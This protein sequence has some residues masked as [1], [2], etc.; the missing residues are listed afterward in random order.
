MSPAKA[1]DRSL[2]S[3]AG[4]ARCAF[5]AAFAVC[6]KQLAPAARGSIRRNPADP[7][8]FSVQLRKLSGRRRGVLDWESV[9]CGTTCSFGCLPSGDS[10][11]TPAPQGRGTAAR[12]LRWASGQLGM[13]CQPITVEVSPLSPPSASLRDAFPQA[14]PLPWLSRPSPTAPSIIH[15]PRCSAHAHSAGARQGLYVYMIVQPAL[16]PVTT[17]T[18]VRLYSPAKDDSRFSGGAASVKS[19]QDGR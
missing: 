10:S 6:R 1:A 4:L 12:L 17:G 16:V 9:P 19:D 7:E 8:R 11:P 14:R 13:L 18:Q 15:G 2:V 3:S 5:P